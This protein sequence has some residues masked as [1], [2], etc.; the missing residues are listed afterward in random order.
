MIDYFRRQSLPARILWA[1]AAVALVPLVLDV[2]FEN[3]VKKN[4]EITSYSYL[5]V[6]AIV[7]ALC[8]LLYAFR[9]FFAARFDGALTGTVKVALAALVLVSLLQGVRGTGV[10]PAQTGC[11]ASYSLKL[12]R[13]QAS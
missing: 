8:G 12:C 1:T 7:A 9:R 13:P 10:V 4:G 11:E 2:N 3:I 6:S 5:G